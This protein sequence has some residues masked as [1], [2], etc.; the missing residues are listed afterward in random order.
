MIRLKQLP[1]RGNDLFLSCLLIFVISAL[2]YLP[3]IG[4]LDYY[5][6]DWQVI[7]SGYTIGPAKIVQMFTIDRPLQ[8]IVYAAN[9]ILLGAQPLGW[10]LYAFLQRMIGTLA[11]LWLVRMLWPRQ[12]IATVAM[13]VLF[14]IYPGFLLMPNASMHQTLLFGL[15][16]GLFSICTTVRMLLARRKTEQTIMLVLSV[17]LAMGNA[18]LFEWMI[19]IEGLRAA[20]IWYVLK[21]QQPRRL[22]PQVKAVFLRWLPPLMGIAVFLFWRV[23]LFHNLRAGT[24]LHGLIQDYLAQPVAMVLRIPTELFKGFW[25]ATLSAWAVPLYNLTARLSFFTFF[26]TVAAGLVGAGL[27]FFGMRWIMTRMQTPVEEQPSEEGDW[28]VAAMLIGAFSIVVALGPVVL[29]GRNVTLTGDTFDRYTLTAMAGAALLVV[30]GIS[31]LAEG[32]PNYRLAAIALLAGLAVTTH[33]AN[34]SSYADVTALRRQFW[35]QLSWRAPDLKTGTLLM[36]LLPPGYRFND[37]FDIFPEANFIYRP[38]VQQVQIAVNVLNRDTAKLIVSSGQEDRD[39]R[40]NVYHR[41]YTKLLLATYGNDSGP[42]SCMHVYDGNTPELSLNEESIILQ[43]APFSKIDQ[44]DTNA[45]PHQPPAIFFGKEPPRTWCY[46]YQTASLERQR[47][48]WQAVVTL[49]QQAADQKF[50]PSDLTEWMP[51]LE[52]EA[53]TGHPDQVKQIAAQMQTDKD[54]TASLCQR[55]KLGPSAAPANYSDPAAFQLIAT[56]LCGN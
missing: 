49:G 54:L 24:D 44:I 30:G 9:Y 2:A 25:D 12:K 56:T 1:R 5:R 53:N 23:F 13:A 42:Q 33:I 6:D 52:A 32:S 7:W 39:M 55:F 8:G 40:T 20:L 34:A 31:K 17:L 41:D 4:Q 37:D 35:W 26:L 3:L 10:H 16:L 27:F 15:N 46:Y 36:P 18:F 14:A 38:N 28:T 47:G 22:W 11:F 51:F 43:V 45:A 48:N 21:R 29:T 19:G 50:S